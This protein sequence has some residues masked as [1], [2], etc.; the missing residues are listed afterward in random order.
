MHEILPEFLGHNFVSG[1][2]TLKHIPKKP[3][4]KTFS[5]KSCL[6][7]PVHCVVSSHIFL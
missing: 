7:G 2:R 6:I 3:N 1:F 4:Q 5:K